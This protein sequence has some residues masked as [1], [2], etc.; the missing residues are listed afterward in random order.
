MPIKGRH[1]PIKGKLHN[2]LG[3]EFSSIHPVFLHKHDI[4]LFIFRFKIVFIIGILGRTG[5]PENDPTEKNVF[6][7]RNVGTGEKIEG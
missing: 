2:L 4:V 5:L 6:F 3:S 1:D 7:S